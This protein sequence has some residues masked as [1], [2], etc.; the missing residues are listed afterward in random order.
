MLGM[1]ISFQEYPAAFAEPI[2]KISVNTLV[3]LPCRANDAFTVSP[4]VVT[5]IV[6]GPRFSA[7]FNA[8][9][10]APSLFMLSP[11]LLETGTY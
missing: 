1:R 7:F 8:L 5:L 10:A 4:F 2:V 11:R 3:R 9:S 6:L